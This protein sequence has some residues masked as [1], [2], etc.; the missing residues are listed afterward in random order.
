MSEKQNFTHPIFI[1]IADSRY[2]SLFNNSTEG[3]IQKMYIN[4]Y[5][6][7][8]SGTVKDVNQ[9]T[10]L[11]DLH[12]TENG[13]IGLFAVADGVGGL[14]H[15]EIA[16]AVAIN[17]LRE[18]W[19]NALSHCSPEDILSHTLVNN[20]HQINM[21]MSKY[22]YKMAT[23]LS[24]LL[25]LHDRYLILH[26]GDSRIYHYRK[27]LTDSF[28][29]ITPD[30]SSLVIN[31]DL[32]GRTVQKSVL[33]DCLGKMSKGGYYAASDEIMP[34]DTFV[35]CSDGVY[36]TQSDKEIK[37]CIAQK[38]KNP[39]ELCRALINGAKQNHETDNISAISV[40]ISKKPIL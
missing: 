17:T 14:E 28:S 26:I 22:C 23:T 32:Y 3:E 29:Q 16:S 2:R 38:K 39:A 40:S 15:G 1:P 11:C 9:D 7:S 20:I 19:D 18:W 13:D 12:R 37:L 6:L 10:I 21:E 30:H 24:S 25:I 4:W 33:T 36:K 34:K 8:D 27:G 5:G 31:K 35:L